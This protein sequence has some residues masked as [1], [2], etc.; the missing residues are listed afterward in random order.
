MKTKIDKNSIPHADCFILSVLSQCHR[1]DLK[2]AAKRLK[3]PQ[4]LTHKGSLKIFKY[5]MTR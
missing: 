1:K 3:L 2:K 5:L 4:R